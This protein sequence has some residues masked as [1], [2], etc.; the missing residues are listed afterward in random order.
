MIDL[1]SKSNSADPKHLGIENQIADP[2]I[3]D[4]FYTIKDNTANAAPLGLYGFAL[5]TILLNLH[6]AGFF[7]VSVMIMAMGIFFG[8]IAQLIAG[9][10]EWRKG[11][12][13]GSVAFIAYGSFWLTLVFIWIAPSFGLERADH[14]SMGSYLA[15]WGLFSFA[16]FVQT[17]KGKTIGILLFGSLVIL[18][19]LLAIHFFTG[20]ELIGRIAGYEGILCGSFAF[21]E[22]SAIMINE[23]YG[24]EILPM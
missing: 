19:A 18:F 24:K 6:N 1:S 3:K 10:L 4:N 12:N 22:A 9:I 16:F 11:N 7:P 13:F 5:T 14:L 2:I 15:I 21:Y 20:S 17:F 23:R 8:G